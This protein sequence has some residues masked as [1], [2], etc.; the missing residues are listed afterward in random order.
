MFDQLT[1][2]FS[3]HTEYFRYPPIEFFHKCNSET[4]LQHG[5]LKLVLEC[6]AIR[7]VESGAL[8]LLGGALRHGII[9]RHLYCL[10]EI[11]RFLR[12]NVFKRNHAIYSTCNK[13]LD[14]EWVVEL[15]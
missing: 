1:E 4:Y 13:I 10:T 8:K 5:S 3:R 9:R 14:F 2:L 12:D 15:G 7:L 6:G 11:F